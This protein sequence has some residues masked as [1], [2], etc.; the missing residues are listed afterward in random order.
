MKDKSKPRR[1]GR[2]KSTLPILMKKFRATPERQ[3]EF[4]KMLTGDAAKDFDLLFELLKQ[5]SPTGTIHG[6]A[7]TIS[8]PDGTITEKKDK[9]S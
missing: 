6:K 9:Q 8:I 7:F 2:Q 1:G 4:Y 5:Q 3:E